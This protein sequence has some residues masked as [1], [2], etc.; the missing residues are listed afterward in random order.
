MHDTLEWR[1]VC[2][3]AHLRVS[4]GSSSRVVCY[5]KSCQ[6][7]AKH[8][9]HPELLDEQGGSDLLQT[10]PHLVEIVEGKHKLRVMRLT[11]RG[12]FR[13]YSSCCGTPV[14]NT[15]PSRHLSFVSLMV[16]RFDRPEAAG[17][18]IARVFTD[19]AKGKAPKSFGTARLVGG[20]A[21]RVISG[22]LTGRWR[23]NPFFNADGT[24]ISEPRTL[25]AEERRAAYAG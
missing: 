16:P 23:D 5:C 3:E 20:V 19:G 14:C 17:R 24:P 25:S 18:V 2:G 22:K 1:C 11:A 12:P 13:W 4:A 15:V 7:A 21:A 10:A 9:G 6:G 8:L